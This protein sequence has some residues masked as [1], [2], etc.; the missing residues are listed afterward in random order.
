MKKTVL[1]IAAM[2]MT[3]TA[4]FTAQAGVADD[5]A[6]ASNGM[7]TVTAD[8]GLVSGVTA[9]DQF[10][11]VFD[12][13]VS[14][15]TRV[16]DGPEFHIYHYD[17]VGGGVRF[18]F[19]ANDVATLESHK[20]YVDSWIAANIQ[21]IVPAGTPRDAAIRMIFD[22]IVEHYT[23]DYACLNNQYTCEEAQ[24]AYYAITNQR[25]IC[26]SITKLFRGMVESLPL[27][28]AGVVDYAMDPSAASHIKVAVVGDTGL[29]HE[30]AAIQ[31]ADGTWYHYDPSTTIENRAKGEAPAIYL[32][33][34]TVID[35]SIYHVT[36]TALIGRTGYGQPGQ[37]IFEY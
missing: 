3:M 32:P 6:A 26:A 36:D 1:L 34:G 12:A 22:Y 18:T 14:A 10:V 27:N 7:L 37:M 15:A 9:V 4:S 31:D 23:Y 19:S 13:A 35:L 33:D 20:A 28:A 21:G 17:Y 16:C 30:W 25:G 29:V 5:I 2:V 11:P 24:G 8:G